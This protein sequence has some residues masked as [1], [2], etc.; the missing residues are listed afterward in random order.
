MGKVFTRGVSVAP[1]LVMVLGLC[2]NAL[3]FEMLR[4]LRRYGCQY[5]AR[6]AWYVRAPMIDL[7]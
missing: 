1:T 6:R 5:C 2:M 4:D 3:V 7:T